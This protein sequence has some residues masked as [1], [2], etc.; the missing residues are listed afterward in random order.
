MNLYSVLGGTPVAL[1]YRSATRT[2]AVFHSRNFQEWSR[3]TGGLI[4]MTSASISSLIKIEPAM[5]FVN[6]SGKGNSEF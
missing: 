4:L 2:V 1:F 3:T 5:G 6:V